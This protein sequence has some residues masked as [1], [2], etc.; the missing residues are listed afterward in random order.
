MVITSL[1][2]KVI[3]EIILEIRNMTLSC[4]ITN[5]N[6]DFDF[7]I[8][9]PIRGFFNLEHLFTKYSLLCHYQTS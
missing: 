4:T 9:H 1:V 6:Y 3:V 2:R 7:T 5:N 8:F